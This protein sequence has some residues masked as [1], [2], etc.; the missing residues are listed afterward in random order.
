MA[1]AKTQSS[2]IVKGHMIGTRLVLAVCD[3]DVLGKV[4]EEKGA[5]LDMTSSFYKGH[6]KTKEELL[7]ILKKVYTVNIVGKDS[8]AFFK[9]LLLVNKDDIRMIKGVPYTSI[10][11]DDP[12][13]KFGN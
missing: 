13:I 6:A 7:A 1:K 8:V 5:M 2:F 4:Y 3:E 9:G 12:H 10:I 11:L